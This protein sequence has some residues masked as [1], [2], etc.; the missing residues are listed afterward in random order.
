MFHHLMLSEKIKFLKP[1][2]RCTN[3]KIMKCPNE[4]FPKS[5]HSESEGFSF[6]NWDDFHCIL[7]TLILKISNLYQKKKIQSS[8]M[9]IMHHD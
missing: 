9:F 1:Q 7:A 6:T 4:G 5:G 2:E 8:L 3:H